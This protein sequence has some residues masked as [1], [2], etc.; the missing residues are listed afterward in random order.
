MNEQKR[1]YNKDGWIETVRNRKD[2]KRRKS[3][4]R[5]GRERGRKVWTPK[6]KNVELGT[7]KEKKTSNGKHGTMG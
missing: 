5:I 4:G 3:T 1:D 7:K 2:G 6:W